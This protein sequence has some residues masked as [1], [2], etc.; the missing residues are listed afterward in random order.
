[1]AP[2]SGHSFQTQTHT[3][4]FERDSGPPI[5]T[6]SADIDRVESP[7]RSRETNFQLLGNSSS[8][9]VCHSSQYPTTS[10]HV[11]DS[12]TSNTGDGCDVSGLAREIGV[13][14][15]A[16]SSAQQSR[17][18]LVA[19]SAVVP[20]LLQLFV[21]LF[22]PYRQDLLSQQGQRFTLDGK[23]SHLHAWR[24]SCNITKQQDFWMRSQ[25]LPLHL[26]DRIEYMTIGGFTSL[27]MRQ[28]KD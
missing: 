5:Q 24:L 23:S 14:V 28:G 26:G 9:H 11:S 17:S 8:G 15:S 13:H 16:V 3:R 1:M 2:S 22:F 19:I 20:H 7:F 4:L 18:S 25:D 12:R 10:F 6:Q 21:D 27:S